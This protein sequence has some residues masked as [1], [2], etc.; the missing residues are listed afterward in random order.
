MVKHRLPKNIC[1]MNEGII[2]RKR[3]TQKRGRKGSGRKCVKHPH[4]GAY[5][6]GRV[7]IFTNHVDLPSFLSSHDLALKYTF[8]VLKS[9]VLGTGIHQ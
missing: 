6:S 5:L 2:I 7:L 8:P 3:E 1:W 4:K 9:S